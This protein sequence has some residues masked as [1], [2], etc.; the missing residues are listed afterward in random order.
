MRRPWLGALAAAAVLTGVR[1]AP[2][3]APTGGLPALVVAAVEADNQRMVD[4]RRYS[5]Q[6][7]TLVSVESV[8]ACLS[9]DGPR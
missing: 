8:R 5:A 1:P 6:T 4:G 3:A 2:A 9:T 7:T